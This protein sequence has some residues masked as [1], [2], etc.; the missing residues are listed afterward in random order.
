MFTMSKPITDK[1][2]ALGAQ[3]RFMHVAGSQPQSV[4][5]E[6]IDSL[7]GRVWASATSG[8]DTQS[9]TEE[10]ALELAVAQLNPGD[11]PKTLAEIAAENAQLTA[12]KAKLQ[13]ELDA[14]KAQGAK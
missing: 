6:I 13:K 5:C 4:K 2:A 3:P 11:K 12:E 7:T 10:H 1:L 14:I 8:T 9:G